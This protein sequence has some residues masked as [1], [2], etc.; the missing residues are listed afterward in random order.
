M[1]ITNQTEEQGQVIP[2]TSRPSPKTTIPWH[3]QA[4]GRKFLWDFPQR[5]HLIHA[6]IGLEVPS[7]SA[8][9]KNPSVAS[10]P[11]PSLSLGN[12]FFK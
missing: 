12:F 11:Y 2:S 9:T 7:N 6:V 1:D 4:G 5:A 8:V 3:M 10:L